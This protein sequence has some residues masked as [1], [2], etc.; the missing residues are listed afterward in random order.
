MTEKRMP[1]AEKRQETATGLASPLWLVAADNWP[2]TGLCGP[3]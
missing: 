3:V 2:D 1:V